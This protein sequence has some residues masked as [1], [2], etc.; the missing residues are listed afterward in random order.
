MIEHEITEDGVSIQKTTSQLMLFYQADGEQFTEG[1]A[2]NEER[3]FRVGKKQDG[4]V[5]RVFVQLYPKIKGKYSRIEKAEVLFRVAESGTLCGM[6]LSVYGAMGVVPHS[7][8]NAT[9][10]RCPGIPLIMPMPLPGGKE[11]SALIFLT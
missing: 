3:L 10:P 8:S 5:R 2:C 4:T 11:N 9:V 1:E 6:N 7:G